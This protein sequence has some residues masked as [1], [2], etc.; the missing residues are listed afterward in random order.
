MFHKPF[1]STLEMQ[2]TFL[3]LVMTCPIWPVVSVQVQQDVLLALAQMP[4][5][6]GRKSRVTR[7]SIVTWAIEVKC[8]YCAPK[9]EVVSF[10]TSARV[11]E[12]F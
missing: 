7:A 12:R 5:Q 10:I 6:L 4:P 3:N 9:I 8:I 1:I 11:K 2:V